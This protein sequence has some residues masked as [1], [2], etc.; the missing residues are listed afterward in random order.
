MVLAAALT[1]GLL[2]DALIKGAGGAAFAL[3]NAKTW[4]WWHYPAWL[5]LILLGLEAV[6]ALV[7]VLGRVSGAPIIR[8]RGKHLDELEPLDKLFVTFNRCTTAVFTYHAI[9]YLWYAPWG[10]RIAWDVRELG[11]VNGL[12]AFVALYVVY[13]LFYT[14]FHRALHVRGLY[15]FIHKHH[16]RQKAPSRGNAD[17]VNVHPFEF[18][19]GEYNHLLALHLVSRYIVPVHVASAAAFVVAGGFLAS[20]NHTR[21]DVRIPLVYEVSNREAWVKKTVWRF[22]SVGSCRWVRLL[23]YTAR[24]CFLRTLEV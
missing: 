11:L 6:A 16:H 21:F 7:H 12:G 14:V 15:K 13:D 4:R 19:S 23:L 20:L 24:V 10:G 22:Y 3:H 18:L 5:S 17:A 8:A 1:E 9:R 2:A